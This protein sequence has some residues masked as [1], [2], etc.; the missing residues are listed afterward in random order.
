[1]T[2]CDRCSNDEKWP[3]VKDSS[4]NVDSWP[5]VTDAVVIMRNG[6]LL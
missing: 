3:L 5:L 4:Y 6:G 2:S 1:M